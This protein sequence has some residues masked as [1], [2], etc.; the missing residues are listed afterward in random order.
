LSDILL[1]PLSF[2]KLTVSSAA[3][4]LRAKSGCI[5]HKVHRR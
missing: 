4:L 1:S 2:S 5:G 3:V